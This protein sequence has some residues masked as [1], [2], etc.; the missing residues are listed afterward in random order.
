MDFVQEQHGWSFEAIPKRL[1]S[2]MTSLTWDTELSTALSST[3]LDEPVWE[4]I[5]ARVVLPL[6]GGPHSST[7]LIDFV[8]SPETSRASG[9]FATSAAF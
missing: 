6:P 7:E 8:M 5:L 4:I 1:A 2:F 9:P 3:Y